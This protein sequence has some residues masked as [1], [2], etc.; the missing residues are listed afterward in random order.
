[1]QPEYI[2]EQLPFCEEEF[3]RAF[4]LLGSDP[5]ARE[6]A[7]FVVKV[8]R[9]ANEQAERARLALA[10]GSQEIRG[11]PSWCIGDVA[12]ALLTLVSDDLRVRVD[13]YMRAQ[14]EGEREQM[15]RNGLYRPGGVVLREPTAE[16]YAE[17]DARIAEMAAEWTALVEKTRIQVGGAA[18]VKPTPTG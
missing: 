17:V 14:W 12:F 4:R 2:D 16:V 13:A 1:M 10:S 5:E 15:L 7:A 3:Y 8:V 11:V 18:R 9:E 6:G